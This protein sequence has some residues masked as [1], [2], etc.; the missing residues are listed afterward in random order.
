VIKKFI[1]TAFLVL[2]YATFSFSQEAVS[3]SKVDGLELPADQTVNA[4]E[5][6]VSIKATCGGEV[7]WLVVSAVKVKYITVP[8]TNS[9]IISVPFQGGK[10]SVFAIGLVNNKQTD[11][12]RTDITVGNPSPNPSPSPSP[13]SATGLHV[14]FLVDMNATTPDLAQILNSQNLRTSISSKG[15]YFRIYDIRSPVLAQKRLDAVAQKIGG[16]SVLVIQR[17]DGYVLDARVIPKTEAEI[18]QLIKTYEGK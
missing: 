9:I 18:L 10:I 1:L 11:F 8:Q 3:A 12:A 2:A 14:T 4:D 16:N 17:S 7:K 6:F 15:N 5:G 13:N